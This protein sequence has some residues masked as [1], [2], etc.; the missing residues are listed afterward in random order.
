[1]YVNIVSWCDNSVV[2][3]MQAEEKE[4]LS[5]HSLWRLLFWRGKRTRFCEK[6]WRNCWQ[7][8]SVVMFSFSF[9]RC[10]DNYVSSWSSK[11]L[12]FWWNSV[13]IT[14]S[15]SQVYEISVR[16]KGFLTDFR[17]RNERNLYRSI[18]LEYKIV[19]DASKEVINKASSLGKEIVD[20]MFVSLRADSTVS[21][22]RFYSSL[23]YT[24]ANICTIVGNTMWVFSLCLFN[25]DCTNLG[26]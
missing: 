2:L 26:Y 12:I 3:Y 16:T 5:G 14:P 1:M 24:Q 25:I 18:N 7:K 13:Q 20:K 9:V 6:K 10:H 19:E 11:L 21:H 4:A 23:L 8:V 22:C 15:T 17:D